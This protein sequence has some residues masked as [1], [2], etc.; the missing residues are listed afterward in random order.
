MIKY[1]GSK[2]RLVPVIENLF[3]RS[4]ARTALDLF[5]GTT[6]V[7]RAFKARG[8]RVTALDS[9]RYAEMLARCYIATDATQV[10]GD[11]LTAEVARLNALPGRPGSSSRSTGSGSTPSAT[12]SRPAATI[13]YSPCWSRRYWRLPTG[14][15][16]PPEYR[17]PT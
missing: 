7:G 9:T 17:W 16:P 5:S 6:R 4:G 1:L 3:A 14:S 2:R 10:D 11:R 13:P 15:I 12:T 8:A